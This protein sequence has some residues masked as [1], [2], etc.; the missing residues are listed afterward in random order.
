MSETLQGKN[1]P[2]PSK[3]FLRIDAVMER[4]GLPRASIYEQMPKG[5]FP[6]NFRLSTRSVGWLES[7]VDSWIVARI[8]ERD[9]AEGVE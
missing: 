7:D 5:K 6:N 3:R 9:G 1:S 2:I 4:T 8:A